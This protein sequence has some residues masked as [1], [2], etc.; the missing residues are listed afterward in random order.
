MYVLVTSFEPLRAYIFDQGLGR[1]ASH[2]YASR[3]GDGITG[4]L[5]NYSLNKFNEGYE[6]NLNADQDGVGHKWSLAAVYRALDERGVDTAAVALSIDGIVAK[7]LIA[8]QPYVIRACGEKSDFSER[9]AACFEL[10]GFDVMLDENAR[11]WLLEVNV[12]PDLASSSPL[13]ERIKGA[14]ASDTFHIVGIRAPASLQVAA[15]CAAALAA[16]DDELLEPTVADSEHPTPGANAASL[17]SRVSGSVLSDAE[18]SMLV[19]SEEEWY[20][21]SSTGFR[22]VFPPTSSAMRYRFSKLLPK[23]TRSDLLLAD[24]CRRPAKVRL[25]ELQRALHAIIR[26]RAPTGA[27][28]HSK[29]YHV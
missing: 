3:V 18:V 24:H 27:A 9:G 25:A 17:R 20:R 5:T 14:L 8:A 7:T 15:V 2:P 4:H 23:P 13:D 16:A 21:C 1:F 12:S 28:A 19:E 10:F 11:P 22:R 6:A 29:V 26:R